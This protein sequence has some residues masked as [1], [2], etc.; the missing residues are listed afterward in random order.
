MSY[1]ASAADPVNHRLLCVAEDAVQGFHRYPFRTIARRCGLAEQEVMERLKAMLAAGTIRRVRQT[2][3]STSLADGALVAWQVP[4][5]KL[6]AAYDWLKTHDP[7]TGHIVIRESDSPDAPGS[8]YRL[9][10]TLKVPTGCGSVQEH[11]NLLMRHT[12]ALDWVALPVVGMFALGVGHARRAGLKPGDRLPEP[13]LMQRPSHP[14]LSK[15]EW[16]VLLSLKESLLPQELVSSPWEQRAAAIGMSMDEYC[17]IAENLDARKIIGRFATFLDH[18][19]GGSNR[20]TGTGAAGLFHWAVPAGMEERAGAECGRH[21]CMTHCY[22][23]SG[24]DAFGGAQIMGVVHAATRSEVLAH[25]AAIDEHLA[26]CGIPV[27]HTAV[28]WSLKAEIRP[29]EISPLIYRDWLHS[30]QEK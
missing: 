22:W 14:Q 13:P 15:H 26:S 23:R 24:G 6:A 17:S 9:W 16:A 5:E 1:P 3:L 27:H 4:E 11:N 8:Q 29:S 25:K 19:R 21:L 7:F 30:M 28:F 18:Q 20:R 12:G 10:T 2:L